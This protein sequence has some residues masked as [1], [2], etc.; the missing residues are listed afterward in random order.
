VGA[1]HQNASQ[2]NSQELCFKHEMKLR[3]HLVP[4]SDFKAGPTQ[5]K[6]EPVDVEEIE[7]YWLQM[8]KFR[9]V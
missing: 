7:L 8:Y 5:A 1:H 4:H 2:G 3:F 9:L 6:Q